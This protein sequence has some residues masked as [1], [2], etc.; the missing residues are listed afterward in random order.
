MKFKNKVLGI[1][2]IFAS[3]LVSVQASVTVPSPLISTDWLSKNKNDVIILDVQAKI[4]KKMKTIDGATIV[5]WKNVR[6]KKSEDG[7]NLIKMVPSKDTFSKLM[8]SL[9][10][11]NNSA[12]VITSSSNDAGSTFL[13]T[14]LY[15]QL[16]Y[17]G[18]DNVALLDGGNAKWESEKR[19]M[20]ES[21]TPSKGNFVA[22]TERKE[23]LATTSDVETALRN[24]DTIILDGRP[25]EQYLGL[26][27]KTKYVYGAG[28]IPGAKLA[29]GD[30]FL[31]HG[32]IK[33][34]QDKATIQKIFDAK[35]I[36][37]SA[38]SISYCNSGHMASGLWFIEHELLGNKNIKL[39]DGSAHA[40]TKSK[41]RPM[42]TF[43]YE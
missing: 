39:Y 3:I 36:D 26:F 11:N 43:K 28:H 5:D 7:M 13:G 15:W 34:F 27:Y 16:K 24:K 6:D 29:Y 1:V 25:E 20:G 32:K 23:L 37:T 41:N 4:T 40:W 30:I 38:K 42:T 35:N 17:F 10:V 18:H 12:I 19:T 31:T 8:Q 21:A 22:K 14:R 9:G 2:A 33:T